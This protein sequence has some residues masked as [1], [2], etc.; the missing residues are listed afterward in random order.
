M[1]F[2]W[3]ISLLNALHKGILDSKLGILLA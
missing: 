3:I 2:I 1:F